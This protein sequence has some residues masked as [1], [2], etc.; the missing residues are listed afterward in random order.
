MT[1][2]PTASRRRAAYGIAGTLAVIA[3]AI[4]AISAADRGH[5]RGDTVGTVEAFDEATG[6]LTIAPADGDA[7]SG[8]VTNRTKIQCRDHDDHGDDRGHHGDDDGDDRGH[9][10]DD[11]GDD[12]P[13]HD[14]G[15]DHGHHGSGHGKRSQGGRRGNCAP[16]AL[17]AGATVEDADLD[18]ESTGLAFEEVEL[19]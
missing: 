3:I 19:R 6:V 1:R 18:L 4:P 5:D 17:V 13:N 7:V 15:D 2:T 10:G 11:D 14:V 8:M 12:G 9:H 16:D